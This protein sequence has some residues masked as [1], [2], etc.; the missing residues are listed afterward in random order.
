MAALKIFHASEPFS[1]E[2]GQ[3]INNLTIGYHTYGAVNQQQDNVVWICHALTASSDAADWWDGLVGQNKTFDPD[4]YFIICANIIG[5]CYGSTGPLSINQENNQPYYNDFP[6][7]TIRDMVNAHILLRKHL[8]IDKIA[9]L[10]GGSMGGYQCLEWAIMEQNVIDKLF[11]LA[12]SAAE[13]TWGI[14]IHTAQRMAIEADQTFGEAYADAGKIGLKAA[15]AIGLLTYRNYQLFKE[16]QTDNDRNKTDSFKVSSYLSYQGKKLIARFNAYSYY[17]LTK[18]MD[19]HNI[20]RNRNFNLNDI[21][22]TIKNQSLVIGISSDILCPPEE[23]K[24]LAE[25][26]PNCIYQEIDSQ[27]GHDGFLV[28][29]EKIAAVFNKWLSSI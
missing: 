6:A 16:Q 29:S 9:I 5:S 3:I 25:N 20:S 15:R 22:K 7:I 10:A 23:Q 11:L 26:L 27:Y 28:E 17:V 1:L 12:T 4:K 24:A 2:N 19:S 14:G 13:S 18:A 8:K 21:I